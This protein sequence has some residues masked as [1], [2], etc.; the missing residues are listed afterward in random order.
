MGLRFGG[1]MG[2]SSPRISFKF[3]TKKNYISKISYDIIF[4]IILNLILANI[5]FGVIVDAFN[6]MRD[7][8]D[9]KEN[10]QKDKCYICNID[11]FDS[12]RGED[13][14]FH[15]NIKHNMLNYI[16]LIPYLIEKNPQEYS[17][18][19]RFVWT[20]IIG[21]EINWYPVDSEKIKR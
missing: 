16:Y 11:R 5:F 1:G 21:H 6:E 14:D 4:H 17:K 15:R 9:K 13:F 20:S 8:K 19:E 7:E 2:D 3:D 18:A 10:D 12:S